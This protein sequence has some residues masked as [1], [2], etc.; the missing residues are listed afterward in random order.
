MKTTIGELNGMA[1]IDFVE[2]LGLIFEHSPW[3][4]ERAWEFRP[5]LQKEHLHARMMEV[6]GRCSEQE[7]LEFIRKHPDLGSRLQMSDYS[8]QEQQG[9]GLTGL[10]PEEYDEFQAFNEA[11]KQKFGFPF[12]IALK[13][14]SM[15]FILDAM[16]SRIHGEPEAERQ[17]ALQEIADIT[18]FRI[19]DMIL[20][21]E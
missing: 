16:K 21:D 13:G 10:S 8:V 18:R 9:A 4:A 14:K 6:V 2:A 1:R 3:V 7:K 11:Y 12:I 17:R 19:E 20:D 5:F 15:A